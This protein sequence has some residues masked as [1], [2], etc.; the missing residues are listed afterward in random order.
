MTYCRQQDSE[1]WEVSD[2]K[3]LTNSHYGE[4][5]Q[6]WNYLIHEIDAW[7]FESIARKRLRRR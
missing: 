4:E 1:I 3:A 7:I 2:E 6:L 5:K